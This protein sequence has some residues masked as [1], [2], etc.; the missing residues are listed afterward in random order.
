MYSE[1]IFLNR[2]AGEKTRV[3]LIHA[4]KAEVA[5]INC[6]LFSNVTFLGSPATTCGTGAPAADRPSEKKTTGVSNAS[7]DLPASLQE[8]GDE[9]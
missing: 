1:Y 5:K 7:S 9:R 8:T 3:F 2:I 6:M 4:N